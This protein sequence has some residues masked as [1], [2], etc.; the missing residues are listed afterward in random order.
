VAADA[1]G[2]LVRSDQRETRPQLVIKFRLGLIEAVLV[3]TAGTALVAAIF[4]RQI[5]LLK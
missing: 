1:C 3:V 4:H 2:L 5:R